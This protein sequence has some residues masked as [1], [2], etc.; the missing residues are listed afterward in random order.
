MSSG[1]SCMFCRNIWKP[2]T[3]WGSKRARAC[4]LCLCFLQSCFLQVASFQLATRGAGVISFLL[5]L[6]LPK[7]AMSDITNNWTTVRIKSDSDFH[8]THQK[9]QTHI[10]TYCFVLLVPNISCHFKCQQSFE[11]C[12][13]ETRQPTDLLYLHQVFRDWS[14]SMQ[15]ILQMNSLQLDEFLFLNEWRKCCLF[16]TGL[17]NACAISLNS[18][19]VV[20]CSFAGVRFMN[21]HGHRGYQTLCLWDQTEV[22][23][24]LCSPGWDPER[25]LMQ[26]HLQSLQFLKTWQ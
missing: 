16:A 23:G 7:Q 21:I 25:T 5:A 9:V 12:C 15:R 3:M 14:S 4:R 18:R 22:P 1:C 2:Q 11:L 24:I 8:Y 20:A 19:T 17:Q 10:W 6:I 13:T 26:H